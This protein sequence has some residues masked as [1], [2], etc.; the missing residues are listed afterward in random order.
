[1]SH[2]FAF[3]NPINSIINSR[4][5][6]HRRQQK[7]LRMKKF[8]ML[9]F[10]LICITESFAF[11]GGIGTSTS[12]YQISS[13]EEFKKIPDNSTA[14]YVLTNDIADMTPLDITF[15]GHI[16]GQ[17]H[18]VYLNITKTLKNYDY[19]FNNVSYIAGIFRKCVGAEI[20]NLTVNGT[21]DITGHY[22]CGGQKDYNVVEN[23]WTY[24]RW[25][26]YHYLKT[27]K[28]GGICSTAQATTFKSC[29]INVNLKWDPKSEKE[30]SDYLAGREYTYELLSSDSAIGGIVA[31]AVD[32]IFESCS[33]HGQIYS[34]FFNALYSQYSNL[35]TLTW[36]TEMN[37]AG[38]LIGYAEN[39]QI[40][41]CFFTGIVENSEPNRIL[42][43]LPSIGGIIG[44]S[45][46]ST[47]NNSYFSGTPNFTSYTNDD[48]RGLIVGRGYI[49]ADQCFSSVGDY[50]KPLFGTNSGLFS[51]CYSVYPNASRQNQEQE[52]DINMLSMQSWYTQ[53]LP[54]WDFD[55]VWYLPATTNALPLHSIE[56]K[57]EFSGEIIYGGTL[58]ISSQNINKTL[59]IKSTDPSSLDINNNDI[60][61]KRAG[62]ITFTINQ[63]AFGE[64]RKVSKQLTYNVSKRDLK[65]SANTSQSVYGEEI[66]EFKLS[67][68]GFIFDDNEDSLE[69]KPITLCDATNK[70][71]IGQYQ[72]IV[73]G[74]YSPNYNISYTGSTHSIIARTLIAKARD[75]NRKYGANNPNFEIEYDGFVNGDNENIISV[76][77]MAQTTAN[78]LSD[79]GTYKI[80]CSGGTVSPN[81]VFDYGIG[82]MVIEKANL[83][84]SVNDITRNIG[85]P[86]PKFELVFDGF[87]NEDDKYSLDE[88]PIATTDA[89]LTSPVGFYKIDLTGGYD[90]NYEYI[91][92]SGTL[93]IVD[94]SGVEDIVADE[95]TNVKIYTLSGVYVGDSV[96]DLSHG[97]YI[98]KRG[99]QIE[100]I[101]VREH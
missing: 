17:G 4:I 77:P 3:Y 19:T 70:H 20:S 46:N 69:T 80:L 38:G 93:T 58:K 91:L 8:V 27:V 6:G 64:F 72:I 16:D 15:K 87:R 25:C 101:I 71:N 54:D 12:P 51:N 60:V 52:V 14:Y 92:S 96:R 30:Y 62:E 50:Y 21:I 47:I 56:P 13:V 86:N 28:I 66:P 31:S 48:S 57:I 9:L 45:Q 42:G 32:C 23:P 37:H 82:N 59:T 76:Q 83:Y 84:I 24:Y 81:Y 99:N 10:S 44:Y 26:V 89:T 36:S 67:Y 95:N 98:V 22:S 43:Y 65:I 39:C 85:E 88:W 1:M 100:K 7:N 5:R 2:V 61:F 68:D 97:I 34:H 79:A 29:C 40:K 18:K 63:D 55:N 94:D 73:H 49:K 33:G 75:C 78:K 35:G 11:S 90:N 74:A 53:N 41:N